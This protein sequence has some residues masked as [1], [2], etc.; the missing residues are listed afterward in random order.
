MYANYLIKTN[1]SERSTQHLSFL[2]DIF[3]QVEVTEDSF[4]GIRGIPSFGDYLFVLEKYFS[5]GPETHKNL[6][7]LED[8]IGRIDPEGE[9]MVKELLKRIC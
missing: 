2:K 7:L 3:I 4:L 5:S 1:E 8:L 9:T 6:G